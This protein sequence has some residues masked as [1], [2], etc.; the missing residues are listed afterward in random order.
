[1]GSKEG[2]QVH[3]FSGPLA[4]VIGEMEEARVIEHNRR[5]IIIKDP[6]KLKE[7]LTKGVL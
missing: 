6:D 7:M 2:C 1:M 5:E 3:Y 4:R